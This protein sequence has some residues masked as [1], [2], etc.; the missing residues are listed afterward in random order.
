MWLL[1]IYTNGK[2]NKIGIDEFQQ[3]FKDL[4]PDLVLYAS[5]FID[6]FDTCKDIVQEV[7]ARFWEENHKLRNHKLVRPYLYKAVKNKALNY[8]KRGSIFSRL[9]DILMESNI[10]EMET[11]NHDAISFLSFNSLQEDLENAIDEL[12]EQRRKIFRMSRFEQLKHKE[13]AVKLNISPKTV[14]TQI[15]RSLS[16][17]RDKLRHHLGDF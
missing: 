5:R 11:E 4:Y 16:F 10:K 17:L 14:E 15:Y 2:A 1:G 12:P 3:L 13:I 7:F 9:D 8:I 6:D